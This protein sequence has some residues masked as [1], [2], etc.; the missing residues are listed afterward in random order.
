MRFDLVNASLNFLVLARTFDDG[1]II[2]VR[3]H[4]AGLTEVADVGGFE[5]ATH[6]FS[7][8][9][10]ARED[11]NIAQ[12][13]FAAIAKAGGFDGKHVQET[14]QFIQH[15][16]CECFTFDI[17]G[18]DYEIALT[19]LDEFFEHGNNVRVR[20]DFLVG[21]ED[22]R[23]GDVGFHFFGV[24]HEI[25]GEVAAIELHTFDI[26]HF[27]IQARSWILRR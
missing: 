3:G 20:R 1:C 14:A 11:G 17:F 6:F 22:I 12:H 8:D 5:L 27:K 16:G 19:H 25:G 9:V 7:D 13:F 4:A 23:I 2:L 24:G 15:E 21:D 18:D 10:A 26:I